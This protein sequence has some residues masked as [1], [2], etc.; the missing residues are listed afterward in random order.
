MR[1]LSEVEYF[2]KSKKIKITSVKMNHC[3]Q[4]HMFGGCIP[5][6]SIVT[7]NR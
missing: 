5:W 1:L 3:P 6:V 2:K 7:E 4:I